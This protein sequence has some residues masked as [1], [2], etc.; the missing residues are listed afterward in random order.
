[1]RGEEGREEE[2]RG[3]GDRG[4]EGGRGDRGDLTSASRQR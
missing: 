2:T 4:R 1:M 3:A